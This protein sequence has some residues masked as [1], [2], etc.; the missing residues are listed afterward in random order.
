[1]AAQHMLRQATIDCVIKFPTNMQRWKCGVLGLVPFSWTLAPRSLAKGGWVEPLPHQIFCPF[2]G[3]WPPAPVF[4]SVIA[5]NSISLMWT[6]RKQRRKRSNSFRFVIT[7][8]LATAV[9]EP[10]L[11]GLRWTGHL[12]RCVMIKQNTDEIN[13]RPL[14]L[15]I[16]AYIV[17]TLC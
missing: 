8:R 12:H 9:I 4:Y 11:L 16:H 15:R 5:L 1:M 13:V 2:C 17:H 10:R 7:A 6:E 14:T 3:A